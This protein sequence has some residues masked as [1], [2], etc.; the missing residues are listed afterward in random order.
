MAPLLSLVRD[1]RLSELRT[2]YPSSIYQV[3]KALDQEL[4]V[5][6]QTGPLTTDQ[7]NMLRMKVD[8]CKKLLHRWEE[9]VASTAVYDLRL[10]CQMMRL[11][12]GKYILVAD[13]LEMRGQRLATT[14]L[15]EPE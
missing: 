5:L 6:E 3:H 4:H 12:D 15:T 7:A 11:A 14:I 13:D 2:Q 1:V 9:T 10:P 8:S